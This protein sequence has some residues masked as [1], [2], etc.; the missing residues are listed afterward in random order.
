MLWSSLPLEMLSPLAFACLCF[1]VSF[2]LH[3]LDH[4]LTW[5][6]K[7]QLERSFWFQNKKNGQKSLVSFRF[8]VVVLHIVKVSFHKE[9][10]FQMV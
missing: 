2:T 6:Q 10:C 4:S 7:H 1:D 5:W 8:V 9:N 3:R